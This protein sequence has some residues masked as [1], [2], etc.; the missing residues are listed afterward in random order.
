MAKQLS[1]KQRFIKWIKQQKRQAVKHSLVALVATAV[2]IL[3]VQLPGDAEYEHQQDGAT[4]EVKQER[5][6]QLTAVLVGDVT[7]GRFVQEV[8]SKQGYN[9]L[10][11]YVQSY[12]EQ[13]DY[14]TGNFNQ[15][16]LLHTEDKK[17]D[18]SLS[19]THHREPVSVLE[20][21]NFSVVNLANAGVLEGEQ[22][23][24]T[25]TVEAFRFSRVQTVGAGQN[26]EEAQQI[27]LEHVNGMTVATL[28]FT[29][30]YEAGDIPHV[31]R[32]G[33]L[34]ADP[35]YFLEL[36]H[37]A[38]QQADLVVV[39]VHW[40]QAFDGSV[41]PRQTEFARAM[42]EAGADVI[43]GHHPGVLAPVEI[44]QDSV[45]FYSLGNFIADQGWTL[46]RESVMVQYQ[47]DTEGNTRI[48][49]IPVLIREATP[50]PLTG[51][52]GVYHRERIF[53]QL[54]KMIDQDWQRDG[55]KLVLELPTIPSQGAGNRE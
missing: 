19:V 26:I 1:W 29:D 23:G 39:H 3:A 51:A 18:P 30:V 4:G 27:A 45:I 34:P 42:V 49:L 46:T 43:I 54:T 7:F 10:F 44:Y 48:E 11:R 5:D 31:Q 53:R 17:T 25:D 52:L 40:G 36:I 9:Y 33:V 20:R 37:E 8:T 21:M 2:V 32:P 22:Q 41:H 28:G 35:A 13:A 14:V 24:L 55:N 6:P 12:F 50:R 47:R 16:I 15:A 38:A